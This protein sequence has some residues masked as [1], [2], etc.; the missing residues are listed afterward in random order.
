[1]GKIATI[2]LAAAVFG[3]LMNIA[4]S[5]LASWWHS[6]LQKKEGLSTHNS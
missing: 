5:K 4:V 3:S 1:M 2:G 6:R